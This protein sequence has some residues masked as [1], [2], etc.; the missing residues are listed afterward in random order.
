[1]S[2]YLS[3]SVPLNNNVTFD[4]VST[5]ITQSPTSYSHGG[6]SIDQYLVARGYAILQKWTSLSPRFDRPYVTNHIRRLVGIN[7]YGLET[8]YSLEKF[9][10]CTFMALLFALRNSENR[11]PSH[12]MYR[13]SSSASASIRTWDQLIGETLAGKCAHCKI[14]QTNRVGSF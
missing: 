5:G 2:Y 8:S 9:S 1:M 10:T 3:T 6:F 11:Q 4:S 7:E 12:Q 13:L 14:N